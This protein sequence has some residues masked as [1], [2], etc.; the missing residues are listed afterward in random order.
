LCGLNYLPEFCYSFGALHEW[1]VKPTI[2]PKPV[3]DS[4]SGAVDFL[5]V[6]QVLRI[7]AVVRPHY[8]Q[9]NSKRTVALNYAVRIAQSRSLSR[10]FVFVR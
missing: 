7:I 10:L 5:P 4:V 3:C 2:K 8:R 6:A 1:D 9:D